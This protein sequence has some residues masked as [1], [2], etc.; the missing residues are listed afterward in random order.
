LRRQGSATPGSLAG[1]VL[2]GKYH[3]HGN[4]D[5]ARMN[6]EARKALLPEEQRA[7]PIIS[8]P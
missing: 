8:K 2:T 1:G 4:A 5:G 7:A 3:G 6:D